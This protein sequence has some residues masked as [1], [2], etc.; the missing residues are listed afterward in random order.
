MSLFPELERINRQRN[1]SSGVQKNSE[2]LTKWSI[3]N[4]E[5][6]RVQVSQNVGSGAPQEIALPLGNPLS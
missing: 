1:R 4:C 5:K 6:V 3:D 2:I